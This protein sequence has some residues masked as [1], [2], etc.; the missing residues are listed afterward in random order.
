MGVKN[1][2]YIFSS[3][4]VYLYEGRFVVVYVSKEVSQSEP[5]HITFRELV[6]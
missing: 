5:T 4:I 6:G 3:G 2:G 1:N